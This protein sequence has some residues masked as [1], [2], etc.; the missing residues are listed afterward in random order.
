[1]PPLA[2]L[3]AAHFT[4]DTRLLRLTTPLGDD[5]LLAESVHGE[6][7]IGNG[8]RFL[9]TALSLDAGISLRSLLGQ[10]VS[11]ELRTVERGVWRP[12]HG[13]VSSA[14][15]KGAN[16]GFARYAL[17]LEPWTAFL[18]H[19]RDS[20]IFQDKTVLDILDTV[21]SGWQGQGR[22]APEWRLDVAD[23]SVYPVRSLTTQYQESDL[24]FS[25]RLMSEEGLFYFFEHERDAHR[26]VIADHNG[27][28]AANAQAAVRF[29]QPGAV[30]KEDSMDRW[31]REVRLQTNAVE[32]SSWD[33]RTRGVRPV[34][35]ASPSDIQLVC[36]DVPGQYAYA[37]RQHGERMA[38]RQL[39]A[40]EVRCETFTGAGTVRTLAPGTTFRLDGH[41][42]A[43]R[44]PDGERTFLVTRVSHL[45]HNNLSAE[46]KGAVVERL[47][48][49]TAGLGE[50][51]L[52]RNRID[53]IRSTV[54]YR[55]GGPMRP[56]PTVRGQ[57]TAVVVGPPGAAI[58]T[59]R[60]HRVK[61]QFHWQRG[62]GNQ[63][64]HNRL[65]HPNPEG[66]TGAPGDDSAG[67]W[68]RVA[69]PL[70]PIAGANWGS[71]ALPRVGQEVLVDFMDGDIDRPVIIGSV[72]NG[73][74]EMDAQ[75][76]KISHGAGAAT[77]NA[78]MWF[79]GETDGHAH[80]AALSGIKSQ[81]MQASQDGSGAYSQL[82]FDDTAGQ[83]RLSLQRHAAAHKGTDELNLG[84]LRHQADN[85]LL[86]PAGFGAEFKSEHSVAL[87]AGQ[88]MLL[89]ADVHGDQM[90]SRAASE[91]IAARRA[92]QRTYA[93]TAATHNAKLPG[94]VL[95]NGEV[96]VVAKLGAAAETVNFASSG[97]TAYSEP[98]LQLSSPKGIV[99][100]TPA[101]AVLNAGG[102]TS[103]SAAADINL[104]VTSNY[105]HAVAAG[106][107]FFTYGKINHSRRP[108]QETGIRF[109]AA[110][111]HVVCQSISGATNLVADKCVTVASVSGGVR[112]AAKTYVLLAAQGVA[113]KLE[114]GDITI[115]APGKVEFKSGT[116]ELGGPVDGSLS[117]TVLPQPDQI[118]NE[119]FVVVDEETKKPLAHVRYRL[120]SESGIVIEGITDA[121]GRTQRIFS[122]KR[123]KLTLHLPKEE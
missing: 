72:Y 31:R 61:V 15:I 60:D 87:R 3:F 107:C 20:R 116:K 5:V 43:D 45:M 53:A 112:A 100:T 57:Q 44:E 88:G 9:I 46:L 8:Y 75:F 66:Q 105:G 12:F 71:H 1:M 52:Y 111:G 104:V 7:S 14:E 122:S 51:A 80:P 77:G 67:T 19:G 95:D 23:R 78:P 101:N 39:Q 82:V 90:D 6:E 21:F 94:E 25:E 119:A 4:Q 47:G 54:P 62:A 22:L 103:I 63:P 65:S 84:C 120:E 64:S 93:E 26:L 98:Q 91:Q 29:T 37:N 117:T 68:V 118:Y 83:A 40:I 69:T 106:I 114:G 89:S 27:A 38:E 34:S 76:N 28:F 70:A 41:A 18:A 32:L 33:Y 92:M 30:M 108:N 50:R 10:P 123:E 24:A 109:H 11:L 36:R 55:S 79:P 74:G 113:M 73:C 42:V 121:C 115:Q 110:T 56:R 13:H 35:C 97:S 59:D 81:A 2:S 96:A 102:T 49:T 86:Q 99:A 58:H 17:T 16:G 48:D 85:Q